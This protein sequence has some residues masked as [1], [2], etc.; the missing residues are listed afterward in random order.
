MM[1]GLLKDPNEIKEAFSLI[2]ELNRKG[3][4]GEE[5]L[6]IEKILKQHGVYNEN[7]PEDKYFFFFF[8]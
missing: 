6:T 7:S 3:L 8:Y 1:R 4:W 5:D 2:R